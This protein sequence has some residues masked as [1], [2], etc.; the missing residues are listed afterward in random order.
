M[1]EVSVWGSG[2]CGKKVEEAAFIHYGREINR[3]DYNN[4]KKICFYTFSVSTEIL[5]NFNVPFQYDRTNNLYASGKKC[6]SLPS[7]LD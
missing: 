6:S 3:Y 4:M 7:H 1:F 2:C 5:F